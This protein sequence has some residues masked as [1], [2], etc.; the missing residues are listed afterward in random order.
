M[1]SPHVK[2]MTVRLTPSSL[3]QSVR[4][5]GVTPIG[6]TPV[7]SLTKTKLGLSFSWLTLLISR[8]LLGKGYLR[9]I[10]SYLSVLTF[11]YSDG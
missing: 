11:V 9:A 7:H 8:S 3:S 6:C 10:E 4:G 2:D 5:L 1:L